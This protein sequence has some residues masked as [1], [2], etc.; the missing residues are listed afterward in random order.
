MG[1]SVNPLFEGVGGKSVCMK[2]DVMHTAILLI[3]FI[4]LGGISYLRT[5]VLRVKKAQTLRWL[6]ALRMAP[7]YGAE[8][9]DEKKGPSGGP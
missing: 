9:E 3:F 6:Y 7:R 8:R 5:R 2:I 1:G 4:K